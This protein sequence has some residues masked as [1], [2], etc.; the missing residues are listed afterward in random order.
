LLE[1][2]NK[3]GISVCYSSSFVGNHRYLVKINIKEHAKSPEEGCFAYLHPTDYEPYHNHIG[4]N[5][6]DEEGF[7]LAVLQNYSTHGFPDGT[8]IP[9]RFRGVARPVFVID[10][11]L[12]LGHPLDILIIPKEP[13]ES[14]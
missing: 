10:D 3:H 9:Y 14:N 7:R 1:F 2:T 8:V 12:E 13:E 11:H 6:T 5:E 4:E